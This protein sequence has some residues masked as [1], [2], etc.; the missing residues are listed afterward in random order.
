MQIP[1]LADTTKSISARYG[2]LI[3]QLG[4]ALR[5]LFVINPE[6]VVQ[7]ITINDLPSWVEGGGR[8]PGHARGEPQE[9]SASQERAFS[10]LVQGGAGWGC[11]AG[12]TERLR[13]CPGGEVCVAVRLTLPVLQ[14]GGHQPGSEGAGGWAV[15]YRWRHTP[16]GGGGLRAC[17]YT[18][19]G[20]PLSVL[21]TQC[22]H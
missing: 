14:P 3:E 5:G 20:P 12:R 19:L 16:A 15:T 6:G 18:G 4:I 7:H 22:V 2:V 21:P 10:A 1:I 11:R 13:G 17:D 8:G 9:G